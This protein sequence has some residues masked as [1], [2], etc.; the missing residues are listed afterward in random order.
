MK[1][2]LEN[3]SRAYATIGSVTIR[4]K[5]YMK[6][7]K[8]LRYIFP[9][10]VFDTIYPL[11]D[12][13]ILPRSSKFPSVGTSWLQSYRVLHMTLDLTLTISISDVIN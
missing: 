1:T 2:C 11:T 7:L 9:S 4:P 10:Q 3:E 5:M 12:L 6:K 13:A 8:I